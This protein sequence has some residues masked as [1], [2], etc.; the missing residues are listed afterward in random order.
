MRMLCVLSPEER[1]YGSSQLGTRD[2]EEPLPIIRNEAL[3][4]W[5]DGKI[6][7]EWA[8][9]PAA[10]SD[11]LLCSSHLFPDSPHRVP[12][13][14]RGCLV[15]L[16]VPQETRNE[17]SREVRAGRVLETEGVALQGRDVQPHWAPG[18]PFK[19]PQPWATSLPLVREQGRP[20]GSEQKGRG[21]GE[22][23]DSRG[24]W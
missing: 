2:A 17:G 13:G 18:W 1:N 14:L 7:Q 6:S 21:E 11:C 9:L 22:D 10:G 24:F 4:G 16:G 12:E 20:E 5:A 19:S 3:E 8:S 23:L 15:V